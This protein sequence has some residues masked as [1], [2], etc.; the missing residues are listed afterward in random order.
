MVRKKV[1]IYDKYQPKINEQKK[2]NQMRAAVK[3]I[4]AAASNCEEIIFIDEV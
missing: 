4:R 2:L 1:I 3:L